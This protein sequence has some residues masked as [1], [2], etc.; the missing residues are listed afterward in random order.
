[1]CHSFQYDNG[2]V[3]L[4]NHEQITRGSSLEQVQEMSETKVWVNGLLNRT[5]IIAPVFLFF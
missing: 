4:L 5:Y 3:D 2:I 1:M